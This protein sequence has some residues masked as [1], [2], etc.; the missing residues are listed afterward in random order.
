MKRGLENLRPMSSMLA[1]KKITGRLSVRAKSRVKSSG[2]VSFVILG[3]DSVFMWGV[4]CDFG[5]G[6]CLHAG[7]FIVMLGLGSVFMRE[8]SL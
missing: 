7:V 3:L 2:T 1:P 8:C 4:L 5:F 6:F